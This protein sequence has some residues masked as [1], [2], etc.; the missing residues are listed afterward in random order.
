MAPALH[1]AWDGWTLSCCCSFCDFVLV[2]RPHL[3]QMSQMCAKKMGHRDFSNWFKL[4]FLIIPM[5]S[6]VTCPTVFS[7]NLFEILRNFSTFSFNWQWCFFLSIL[8]PPNLPASRYQPY[9]TD[10]PTYIC[11]YTQEWVISTWYLS[12]IQEPIYLLLLYWS[13]PMDRHIE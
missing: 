6:Y 11:T 3:V 10:P 7:R 13:P 9:W 1:L 4:I 12:S 2:C 5:N 8:L